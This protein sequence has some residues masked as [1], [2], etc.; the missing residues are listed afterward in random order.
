MRTDPDRVRFAV[1]FVTQDVLSMRGPAL[2]K[3]RQDV[4]AFLGLTRKGRIPPGALVAQVSVVRPPY[5]RTASKS[6]LFRLQRDARAMLEQAVEGKGLSPT[7]ISDGQ[8]LLVDVVGGTTGPRSLRI[9]GSMRAGFLLT[10]ALLLSGKA[11]ASVRKCLECKRLFI[12]VRRQ[13]YCQSKCTD[14]ATWRNYPEEKKWLARRKQYEKQ[15]WT[16]GARSG[17]KVT[18]KSTSQ[19]RLAQDLRLSP[20]DVAEVPALVALLVQAWRATLP[21]LPRQVRREAH[22][23]KGRRGGT[24]GGSQEADQGWEV[25]LRDSCGGNAH[26]PTTA[27]P[28]RPA[29]PSGQANRQRR[30]PEVPDRQDR[31]H[32]TP[33]PHRWRQAVR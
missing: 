14:A 33:L 16:L 29:L 5:P 19:Q 7:T 18:N 1:D 4:A 24:R 2:N 27:G 11:G 23:P 15:G 31:R 32:S 30:Q 10:L 13:M 8:D 3:L 21:L 22:R 25:R 28:L 12:R 9:G 17:R 26:R 6:M 20:S